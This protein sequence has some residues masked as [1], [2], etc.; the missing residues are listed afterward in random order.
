MEAFW[1]ERLKLTALDEK[2]K[3]IYRKE[4]RNSDLQPTTPGKSQPTAV[5]YT[6]SKPKSSSIDREALSMP[7]RT[8]QRVSTTSSHGSGSGARPKRKLVF[9]PSKSKIPLPK[10]GQLPFRLSS[11]SD[12]S[13]DASW[14]Q[15]SDFDPDQL[16]PPP[17]SFHSDAVFPLR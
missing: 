4:G 7:F 10:G 9:T 8:P 6:P 2:I 11:G 13:P 17:P 3:E 15:V 14:E 5:Y 1:H 12:S 16:F